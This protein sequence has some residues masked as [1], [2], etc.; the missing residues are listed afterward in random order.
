MLKEKDAFVVAMRQ[1]EAVYVVND[2]E[3]SGFHYRL[4]HNFADQFGL[5]LEVKTVDISDYWKDETGDV[6][7][8]QTDPTYAYNPV[9]FDEVDIY[10]DSLTVV[11]WRKKLVQFIEVYPS[12]E[13]VVNSKGLKIQTL[14][15]LKGKKIAITMAGSYRDTMRKLK[16][17]LVKTLFASKL[18]PYQ[19]YFLL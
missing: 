3:I 17:N 14:E 11:P 5:N 18:V 8:V 7:K 4:I 12:R 19:K 1:V 16:K 15:D 6:E 2:D 13:F 10:C 9:L